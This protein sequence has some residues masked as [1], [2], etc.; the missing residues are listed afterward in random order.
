M[1]LLEQSDL[2]VVGYNS[3][4]IADDFALLALNEIPANTTVFVT[5][6]GFAGGA[7]R[8]T[9][10]TITWNTGGSAIA[11]GTLIEFVGS[12]PSV[13]VG[14]VDAALALSTLGDQI[15]I[16]QTSDDNPA[17]SPARADGGGGTENGIIYGFNANLAA[18][19]TNGWTT[20]ATN[21]STT[22]EIPP[23]STVFDGTN[24]A[25]ANAF[26]I[27]SFHVSGEQDNYVFAP[28]DTTA[29]DKAGWLERLMDNTA[30]NWS[31]D[32]TTAYNLT[33]GSGA[34]IL[35]ATSVGV[36]AANSAPTLNGLP[37][38]VV[39]LEDTASDF[40]L[41]A[42]VFADADADVLTV[43]LDASGGSFVAS[44]SGNV[45]VGGSGSGVLTLEGL[46]ADINAWLD[47]TSNIRYTG[48]ADVDGDDA[49]TLAVTVNDGTVNPQLGTSNIDI[50]AV[51]DPAIA[52][53]DE[54]STDE[55]T[56]LN[57]NVTLA[58][59]TTAD[60]DPDS[61]LVITAVNGQAGDVGNQ[62]AL[63]SGALLTVNMDGTFS[64]DPIGAFD[65]LPDVGA[66]G[67]SST[68]DTDSFTYAVNGVS[69]TVTV[70]VSGVDSEGDVL[71][72]TAGVDVLD[73]GVGDDALD[74]GLADD[75]LIGG[76]G[77]DSLTGG[78][79]IDTSSHAGAAASVR[80]DLEFA[81]FSL[82]E[83]AGD[84]YLSV[85]NLTG[86]AFNDDLR[87]DGG[88]NTLVGGEGRDFLT[89]RL[90]D[91]TLIGGDGNDV[92]RGEEGADHLDGGAGTDRADYLNSSLGVVADL[93]MSSFNT[94]DA[95]GD[96]YVSIEDLRG[97]RSQ[98]I[99][100]GDANNNRLE[101]L[102]A[103]DVL[104]GRDGNDT[105]LGGEGRDI[106]IGGD[107]ND[108]LTGSTD[109]DFFAF[110]RADQGI[111]TITDMQVGYDTIRLNDGG[112]SSLALG[113]LS[114]DNFVSGTVALDADDFVIYD[115]GTGAL[116][117]DADGNGANVQVQIATL[118]N[119]ALLSE[120]DFLIV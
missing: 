86:S 2:V 74:G 17:S 43:T 116:F 114:A 26:G 8:T 67:A 104:H 73:G 110:N 72:G 88:A 58:N 35:A 105:L 40:D 23:N 37:T 113:D 103:R 15:I 97:G 78:G 60:S 18:A 31:A 9:E 5:D 25:T 55:A 79:G 34:G 89:G 19:N 32:N 7:L 47:T 50:T 11:A 1:A 69:A 12:G 111:D 24:A 30:S 117:Y 22:S 80:A 45:T 70:T 14:T 21:S 16:Y 33:P 28:S 90:G 46:A 75:T 64:Y 87:G 118:T 61:P 85:E 38:D 101:G 3:D 53:D 59:P 52:I 107:G 102:G 92:L 99:L 71:T 63:A 66:S 57:G 98:D 54:V 81:A 68:S 13:T 56:V 115:S 120:A 62:V 119:G 51:D 6:N 44:T 93:Q 108:T 36:V 94:G 84:T 49:E 4:G 76:A 27:T 109:R 29:T 96:T 95:A 39:V 41:S 42:A 82:G 106:L 91:D 65:A 112:F 77:A 100:R 48:P 10:D 20:G 83:A